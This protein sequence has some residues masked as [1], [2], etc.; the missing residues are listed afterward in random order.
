MSDTGAADTGVLC[1]SSPPS[2][3]NPDV[4][5]SQVLLEISLVRLALVV[6]NRE[7]EKIDNNVGEGVLTANAMRAFRVHGLMA[8]GVSTTR[9]PT[10][11]MQ[12]G[13]CLAN[14]AF[15]APCCMDAC[16]GNQKWESPASI[17]FPI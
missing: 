8:K 1:H 13:P 5:C 15:A 17:A 3:V 2:L 7:A 10:T 12:A 14:G 16:L 6:A 9:L 11:I 4:V